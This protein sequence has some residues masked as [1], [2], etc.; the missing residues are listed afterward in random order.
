M[1]EVWEW[2]GYCLA[3][4]VAVPVLRTGA[5]R[6]R[7]SSTCVPNFGRGADDPLYSSLWT[8]VPD[9]IAP[10]EPL[11]TVLYRD[12]NEPTD[13]FEFDPGEA[14]FEDGLAVVLRTFVGRV[15]P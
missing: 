9:G 12:R 13:P 11:P 14:L 1:P 5:I 15:Q 6:A 10:P 3:P 7:G 2:T 8:S 4:R